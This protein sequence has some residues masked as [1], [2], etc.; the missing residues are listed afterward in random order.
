MNADEIVRALK[1]CAVTDDCYEDKTDCP[2]KAVESC[3]DE[4]KNNAAELIESL[5]AQL[6]DYHHMSRLVDGKMSEN[7][8]LRRINERLQAQLAELQTDYDILDAANTA[9]H[10]SFEESR[11]RADA[12]VEDMTAVLKRDSDDICAYCKNRIECKNEQCEKY[13]SGV[14]DVDGNY[15][16]WK[17]TCMDFDY[18]TC[19]LL[20][21]T[22]CNG[23]FDDDYIGFEWRGPQAGEGVAK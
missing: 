21:D 5:Q 14:G 8:R 17:W 16:D 9:L 19:F 10:G 7:Q 13:S 4:L 1:L 18:G 3:E 22:P 12:A 15:P 6:V 23:C 20:A 2:Y 11:R